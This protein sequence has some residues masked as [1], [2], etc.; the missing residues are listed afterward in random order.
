MAEGQVKVGHGLR[1]RLQRL[2]SAIRHGILIYPS[3]TIHRAGSAFEA[4]AGP[5]AI[6][7]RGEPIPPSALTRRQRGGDDVGDSWIPCWEARA[8]AALR[9]F[10]FSPAPAWAPRSTTP[11]PGGFPRA[12]SCGP[13]GRGGRPREAPLRELGELARQ[14]AQ[15][16]PPRLDRPF[17]LFGH[18]LGAIA[19][20]AA[21]R[22][23][24]G[25]PGRI[26]SSSGR[27]APQLPDEDRLCAPCPTRSFV[28]E[29]RRRYDGIPDG[30]YREPEVLS[31]LLPT[32]CAD[33][34]AIES[35]TYAEDAP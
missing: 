1:P 12:S 17:A 13:L 8:Q 14:S 23:L 4:S 20:C 32:L 25:S 26:S 33:F 30:V 15:A 34:E 9:L 27:R 10:C 21:A 22:E 2:D 31:L 28:E 7:S 3:T 18:S 19:A 11:G 29:V 16:I 6:V 5:K 24:P 35:S